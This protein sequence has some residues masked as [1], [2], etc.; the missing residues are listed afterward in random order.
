MLLT[1]VLPCFRKIRSPCSTL[2]NWHWLKS[3]VPGWALSR[4]P[5]DSGE[6]Q[7]GQ[8]SCLLLK[9]RVTTMS[10]LNHC[11]ISY[12]N[13][14]TVMLSW[15]ACSTIAFS[16]VRTNGRCFRTYFHISLGIVKCHMSQVLGKGRCKVFL[17]KLN[18]L[19]INFS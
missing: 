5:K 3:L 12:I 18:S 8:K 14:Y 6:F 17:W 15:T 19:E 16:R 7:E 4:R 2:S 9:P 10:H 1:N 11:S 13:L